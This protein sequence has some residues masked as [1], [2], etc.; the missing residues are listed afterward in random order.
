M[1][2]SEVLTINFEQRIACDANSIFL[3]DCLG[4]LDKHSARI[5]EEGIRDSLQALS[6]K[7]IN[8][9][10][11]RIYLLQCRSRDN[12]AA[13]IIEIG[14]KCKKGLLPLVFID[15]HGDAENGLAMPNGG[16]IGWQQ[17]G[18]DL[19][20]I[21]DAAH[22]EL[23]VVAGFCHSFTFVKHAITMTDKL[24]FGFYF[25]YKDEV[26][27]SIVEDETQIIYESLINDG[28]R[29]LDSRVL[30]IS[31]FNEYD[32]ALRLVGPVAFMA[33]APRTL[34]AAMPQLSKAKF[35]SATERDAA[36]QGN[37]LGARRALIKQVLNDTPRIAER[38]IDSCMHDTKRRTCFKEQIL[39]QMK[40]AIHERQVAAGKVT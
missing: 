37:R 32:H 10:L 4:E 6:T 11:S 36:R 39:S 28:G 20:A 38:L 31:S 9:D 5:R 19:R 3:I 25:G 7:D 8:H 34:T 40:Q 21:T 18:H 24:P 23:T 16:F 27:T 1:D 17:Y 12:W 26:R 2:D 29:V 35:R 33:I 22:G 13:A 30:Q 14:D 15:G